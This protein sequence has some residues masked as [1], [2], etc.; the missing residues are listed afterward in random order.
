MSNHVIPY[1]NN[2]IDEALGRALNAVLLSQIRN[3]LTEITAGNV[4]D[5]AQG[6]VLKDQID[7]L[8]IVINN[9]SEGLDDHIFDFVRNNNYA[10]DSGTANALVVTLNPVPTAYTDGMVVNMRKNASNN[11]SS[12]VTINV[13][14]LGV[15]N[16]KD[17]DGNA[18]KPNT[19]IANKNYTLIYNSQEGAFILLA[20]A[21]SVAF[22][23]MI[24]TT[25]TGSSAP[26][27]QTISVPGLSS[28][29][30]PI[31]TPI[32]DSNNT[33]AIAQKEAWGAVSKITTDTDSIIVTCF[34]DKPTTAILVQIRVVI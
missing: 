34:E 1:N 21:R 7:A 10:I 12:I 6:K 20:G 32:Y 28:I 4:L 11:T 14:S 30:A 5:A 2:Q 27:T 13:N 25:W 26:Y 15:K 33:T 23:A 29:D 16:I 31:I 24:T 3:T 19:L 8:V 9:I 22:T 17:T 18:I